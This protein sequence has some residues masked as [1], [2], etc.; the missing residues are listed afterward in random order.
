MT[1]I[2]AKDQGQK[3]PCSKVKIGDK[4]TDGRRTDE[5][6]DEQT[7]FHYLPRYNAVN[8]DVNLDMAPL[9]KAIAVR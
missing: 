5:R 9:V 8:N 7:I 2:R 3:S 4:R 1:H 6:T